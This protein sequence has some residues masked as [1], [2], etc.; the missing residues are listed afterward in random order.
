MDFSQIKTFL[1]SA[2]FG[3][4]IYSVY[5]NLHFLINLKLFYEK[6]TSRRGTN[7]LLS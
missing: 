2:T 3:N 1:K 7:L 6:Q 4:V 5:R